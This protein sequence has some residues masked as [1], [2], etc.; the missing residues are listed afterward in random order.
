[1]EVKVTAKGEGLYAC[2]YVPVSAIKHTLALTWGGVSIPRS[3]FRVSSRSQHPVMAGGSKLPATRHAEPQF[4]FKAER[5]EVVESDSAK[6][7][8]AG[9]TDVGVKPKKPVI[10]IVTYTEEK[11]S[12]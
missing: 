6:T 11:Y 9:S 4:L 5:I 10:I 8:Q 2:S 12:F 3:P 1:M 7:V